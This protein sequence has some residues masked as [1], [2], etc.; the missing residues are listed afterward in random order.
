MS[1]DS[2]RTMEGMIM[3]VPEI[4]PTALCTCGQPVH[5][6]S[7]VRM[8]ASVG[9]AMVAG[10]WITGVVAIVRD[11]PAREAITTVYP[12]LPAREAMRTVTVLV[13]SSQGYPAPARGDYTSTP[14]LP[15]LLT[16]AG[17][18]STQWATA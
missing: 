5:I 13:T 2:R 17:C 12:P 3:T 7:V 8:T 11:V 14:A 18:T 1:G 16:T 6:G 15:H 4:P 9:G 10:E